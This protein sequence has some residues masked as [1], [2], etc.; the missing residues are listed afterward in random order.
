MVM[1]SA[2]SGFSAADTALK[3]IEDNGGYARLAQLEI[4]INYHGSTCAQYHFIQSQPSQVKLE[5]K[6]NYN[7]VGLDNSI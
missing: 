1:G 6:K 2:Q 7:K 5:V 3:P 4:I